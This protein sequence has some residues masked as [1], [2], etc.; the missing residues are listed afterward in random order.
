MK[1]I[2]MDTNFNT[3]KEMAKE[4]NIKFVG[5]KKEILVEQINAKIEETASTEK[6]K[7]AG[8]WFEQENAF[9]YTEG[10]L[11]IITNHKNSAILGR[12]VEVV[13]PSTKRNAFKGYLI[14]PNSGA[15]Q[16][17]CL[18]LDFEM[19]TEH[20]PQYPSIIPSHIIA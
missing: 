19:V 15:R 3:I 7:K 14:N 1:K 9:P 10:S 2:S 4:L 12:M 13:G 5:I 6:P 18:S 16:G 8:K 17:T 20:T 11:M